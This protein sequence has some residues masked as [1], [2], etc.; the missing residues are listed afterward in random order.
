MDIPG[1][2]WQLSCGNNRRSIANS[3]QGASQYGLQM[4]GA[5]YSHS[6]LPFN[7]VGYVEP[8]CDGWWVP[9]TKRNFTGQYCKECEDTEETYVLACILFI[10][11]LLRLGMKPRNSPVVR[12]H[13]MTEVYPSP[14]HSCSLP[15]LE[16]VSICVGMFIGQR[17]VWGVVLS[18][19]TL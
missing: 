7:L 5:S 4:N 12:L 1:P 3:L 16:C 17:R 6:H 10:F 8:L 9:D 15:Y 13:A 19:S 11:L 2:G 18:P 14:P